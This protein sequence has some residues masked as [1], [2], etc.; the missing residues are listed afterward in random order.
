MAPEVLLGKGHNYT[1]DLWSL[2]VMMYEM[3]A[4]CLPFAE[5]TEDPYEIFQ[6]IIKGKLVFPHFLL[7][8]KK[9]IQLIEQLLSINNPAMRGDAATIKQAPFF[10]GFDWEALQVKGVKAP[11][12]PHISSKLSLRT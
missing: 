3:L 1:A 9:A 7:K 2:G 4:G 5:E 6:I 10:T 12:I 8:Q 11:Y